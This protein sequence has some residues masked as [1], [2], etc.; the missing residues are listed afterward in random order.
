MIGRVGYNRQMDYRLPLLRADRASHERTAER[1]HK[2][3]RLW[4]RSDTSATAS[5]ALFL[6]CLESWTP[7]L[8]HLARTLTHVHLDCAWLLTP[9]LPSPALSI[10]DRDTAP[11][12]PPA[13]RQGIPG[14]APGPAGV[15]LARGLYPPLGIDR[16]DRPARPVGLRRAVADRPRRC[17]RERLPG[18]ERRPSRPGRDHG[19]W[20]PPPWVRSPARSLFVGPSLWRRCRSRVSRRASRT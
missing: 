16:R 17:G 1:L 18:P 12:N 15:R 14:P 9:G 10:N 2:R 4:S 3:R 13:E 11:A 6:M 19:G 20:R 8:P 7:Q 5:I